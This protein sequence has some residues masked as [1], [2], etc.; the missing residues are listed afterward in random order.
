MMDCKRFR[1]YVGA[2]ADGELDIQHNLDVLDHLKMCP[3]CA[4]RVDEI[5]LL[6]QSV[7]RAFGAARAPQPLLQQIPDSHDA[8]ADA[9]LARSGAGSTAR[10]RRLPRL[11]IALGMAA[12]FLLAVALWQFGSPS[13]IRPG[14]ITVVTG[15]AVADVR[16]QHRACVLRRGL[17]H[18]DPS[19]PR[20]LTRLAQHLQRE[21][22]LDVL[23]PDLSPHGFELVGADRCGIRG[24]PGAHVLYHSATTGGALS[25]FTVRYL[26]EISAGA[27]GNPEA[28]RFFVSDA[29]IPVVAWHQG[30][31]TYVLC[32]DLPSE[33]LLE[34]AREVR[35]AS[36]AALT[37]TRA[38]VALAAPGF[39]HR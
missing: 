9:R 26:P 8:E 20:D 35:Q 34:V 3:S 36:T 21:L 27:I 37:R 19:M 25:V 38:V 29:S 28:S 18:H 5:G 17:R 6:K 30:P 39:V 31:Q 10:S 13:Q 33:T 11:G 22:K 24:R 16:E 7:K 15:R 23:V 14:T 12:A 2:F 32:G 1:K 4:S